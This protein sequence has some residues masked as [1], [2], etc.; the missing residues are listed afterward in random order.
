MFDK[1]AKKGVVIIGALV[2]MVALPLAEGASFHKEIEINASSDYVWAAIRDF[3][4]VQRLVPGFVVD[5]HLD[6][7]VRTVTFADGRVA[8]EFLVTIDDDIMRLV[9]AEPRGPFVTRNASLQ[10]FPEGNGRV[11]VVWIMDLLPNSLAALVGSNMD[12]GLSTMKHTLEG[13]KSPK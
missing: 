13:G 9:Y 10:V 1:K 3:G 2:G 5:C 6:G 7:N 4:G 8:R 12:K 11:K